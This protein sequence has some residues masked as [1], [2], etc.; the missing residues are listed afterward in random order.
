MKIENL[1]MNTENFEK[2][3]NKDLKKKKKKEREKLKEI[4]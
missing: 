3:K 2:F 1:R 4:K